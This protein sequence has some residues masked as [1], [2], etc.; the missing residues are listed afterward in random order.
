V[1]Q[2][3]NMVRTVGLERHQRSLMPVDMIR[4]VILHCPIW[5]TRRLMEHNQQGPESSLDAFGHDRMFIFLLFYYHAQG[6]ICLFDTQAVVW[7][8]DMKKWETEH[9]VS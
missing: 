9:G 8:F 4:A 2:R 3:D 1:H 5:T 6:A 7:L